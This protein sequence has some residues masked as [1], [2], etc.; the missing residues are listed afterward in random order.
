MA[1]RCRQA[2]SRLKR[3]P[4]FTLAL[5]TCSGLLPGCAAFIQKAFS[6]D[7]GFAEE[8]G[9]P[10]DVLATV[11]L[12]MA[13][14]KSSRMGSQAV[15]LPTHELHSF[16]VFDY[17]LPPDC[18]GYAFR[19][20]ESGKTRIL[21]YRYERRPGETYLIRDYVSGNNPF[22]KPGLWS[23]YDHTADSVS[24]MMTLFVETQGR[25]VPRVYSRGPVTGL[26]EMTQR[27]LGLAYRYA[28]EAGRQCGRPRPS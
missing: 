17:R 23:A 22:M 20:Y 24:T 26:G 15:H 1:L 13:A 16:T 9:S 4:L 5:L 7:H 21:E 19:V 27:D 3:T 12:V 11:D 18:G 8:Y 14:G 28:V 25:I 6:A 10:R 2:G